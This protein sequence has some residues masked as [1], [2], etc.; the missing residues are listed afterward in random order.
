MTRTK[1]WRY[2]MLWSLIC[3]SILSAH[4]GINVAGA[5]DRPMP[6]VLAAAQRDARQALQRK[7]QEQPMSVD[8]NAKA[9]GDG[10]DAPS[11]DKVLS[12]MAARSSASGTK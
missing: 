12:E 11:S 9:A 5:M 6:L 8:A 2:P 4:N 7:S 1:L 3:A 10:A